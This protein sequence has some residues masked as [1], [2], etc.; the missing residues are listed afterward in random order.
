MSTTDNL[1]KM[2]ASGNDSPMLRF[3][4]GSAYYNQGKFDRAIV[5]LESCIE[6]NPNYSAAYKMLG[7]ALSAAEAHEKA[8]QTY[9]RG[10]AIAEQQGD[11]QTAK[12]ISVFLKRL[13]K[14]Q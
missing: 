8:R 7:R 11:K 13:D 14:I 2:L 5:H 3:G 9:T 1:E 4:L 12:E 10:L 6:Q